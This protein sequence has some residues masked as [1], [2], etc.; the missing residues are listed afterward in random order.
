MQG[1]LTGRTF[2]AQH[3]TKPVVLPLVGPNKVI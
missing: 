1:R 2:T 3:G